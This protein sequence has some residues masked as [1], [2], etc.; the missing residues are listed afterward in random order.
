MR[1]YHLPV[2]NGPFAPKENFFAHYE[3]INKIFMYLLDPLIVQSQK[4]TL[5]VDLEL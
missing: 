1:I 5:A 2:Q 4:N 3:T